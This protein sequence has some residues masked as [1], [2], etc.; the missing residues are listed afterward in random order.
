MWLNVIWLFGTSVAEECT[1][2]IVGAQELLL[3]HTTGVRSEWRDVDPHRREKLKSH[4]FSNIYDSSLLPYTKIA[5]DIA[6]FLHYLGH[7]RISG[8]HCANFFFMFSI[9]S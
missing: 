5:P 2:S 3:Y 4:D 9:E 8:C 6:V 1:R 7:H